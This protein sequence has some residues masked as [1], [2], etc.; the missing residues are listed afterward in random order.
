MNR[1]RLPLD[2]FFHRLRSLWLPLLVAALLRFALMFFAFTHTGTQ[3]MTQGDTASYLVPGHNLVMNNEFTSAG[4]PEIDRTPAYPLFA[5][6]TGMAWSNVLSTISIQILVSL[7]SLV[8]IR[9]I[10]NRIFPNTRA[11]IIAAW[12]FACEPLSILCTSRVMPETLFLFFLLLTIERIL[13]YQATE[14]LAAVA[15]AGAFL[16]AATYTRPVSYYLGLF[17]AIG[18]AATSPGRRGL[19]WKAPAILLLTVA[20]SLAIWQWRNATEAGYSGFSSIVEKN[21]YFFQSAEVSAELQHISFGA[22]QQKLGYPEDRYYAA[23]HPEQLFWTQSQ[24][25]RFMRTEA[26]A[27]IKDHPVL[28]LKTHVIGV[29]IVAFTPCATELLQLIDAYPNGDV[30]PHRI[31]SLGIPASIMRTMI[32]DPAAAAIMAVLETFLLFQYIFTIRGCIRAYALPSRPQM[33]TLVGIAMYFLL[34][35]GGAQAVGRYR[36]PVMPALCVLAAGGLVSSRKKETA[37]PLKL[38][39]Q[40]EEIYVKS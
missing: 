37:E 36:A 8:L 28:Y 2:E 17:L 21:L 23:A 25:Q 7:A 14:N 40:D 31:L 35:S 6:L 13:A 22:Q 20:P 9:T 12:L 26:L 19:R 18:L 1:S 33:L 5:E 10:A 32:A 34:I 3:V 15:S 24:K 27:V 39:S 38:R 16:A 11:G 29:A 30:M 4:L